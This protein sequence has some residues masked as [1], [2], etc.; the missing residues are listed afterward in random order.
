MGITAENVSLIIKR[1]GG[2][3]SLIHC[4]T[5][6]ININDMANVILS[7]NQSPIMAD[8]P[9]ESSHVTEGAS[10]LLINLGNLQ[11]HREEAMRNSLR[12]AK[13]KNIPAVLDLVGIGVSKLR[14]FL[15]EEFLCDYR[16]DV[17]KGN[18]SEIAA[19]GDKKIKTRGVDSEENDREKIIRYA[20]NL[21]EKHGCTV[22]CTGKSDI[23]Y[24]NGKLIAVNNGT[25]R[26]S[27]I[28]GTGCLTGA[29]TASMIP[30][31]KSRGFYSSVAA[32]T[33]LGI[34]GEKAEKES[35]GAGS[36]HVNLIDEISLMNE[37]TIMENKKW[38]IINLI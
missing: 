35:R 24:N 20:Q 6:A 22:L 3:N 33:L 21:G 23:I 29:I 8:H 12:K 15:A 27:V 37:K 10:S 16:I 13:E 31:D 30:Y 34:A 5:H 32:V 9:L 7:L 19:L 14:H 18:Y 1:M 25:P 28:T 36:F 38:E 17:I 11:P 26:L 4:I 2:E